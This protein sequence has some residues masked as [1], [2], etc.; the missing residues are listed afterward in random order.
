[1]EGM[2]QSWIRL[3]SV[4]LFCVVGGATVAAA[5]ATAKRHQATGMVLRVDGP[6]HLLDVSCDK[7][8]NY[9]SAMEMPFKVRDAKTASGLKVGTKISFLIV[10]EGKT[11]YADDIH[12]VTTAVLE[13]EP[14]EAGGLTALHKALNPDM[15]AKAVR[16]GQPVSDFELTDQA[17]RKVRF[18]EFEGKVVALT[19][20]YSHCPNPTYC[21]RLSNNLAQVYKQL[22][23]RAG[24]ELVLLTIAID[25]EHD[26]GEALAQYAAVFKADPK[27]W[28]FLTGPLPEI[29][30]VAAMFGM[31][32]WSNE[33]LITHSLHTVIVDRHGKLAIN[34]EGNQF[35]GRQLSDLV[36]SVM[37]RPS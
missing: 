3:A 8:P 2:M 33:G 36:R 22:R 17:G 18:S 5:D 1:M 26:Q 20:G 7:I 6:H 11:L 12:V 37:D 28:H 13:P 23:S 35:T 34:L 19:F 24:R 25:P 31:D 16:V 10:E 9:M 29:Q 21:Y 30:D 4:A 32:F 15:T 14:I 27:V